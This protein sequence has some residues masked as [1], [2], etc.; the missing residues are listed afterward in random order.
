MGL[1]RRGTK[2]LRLGSGLRDCCCRPEKP[3]EC[4]CP[5]DLC[6][7]YWDWPGTS[8]SPPALFLKEGYVIPSGSGDFPQYG[9]RC[10]NAA[11]ALIKLETARNDLP[12]G[13]LLNG[14]GNAFIGYPRNDAVLDADNWF[15]LLGPYNLSFRYISVRG[16]ELTESFA[17]AAN[18]PYIAAGRNPL[19]YYVT[20]IIAKFLCGGPQWPPPPGAIIE[21]TLEVTF[22]QSVTLY[23]EFSWQDQP[24]EVFYNKRLVATAPLESQCVNEQN[25]WCPLSYL[26]TPTDFNQ[27]HLLG[28]VEIQVTQ[29]HLV[30]NSQNYEWQDTTVPIGTPGSEFF[31]A[32]DAS[33][34]QGWEVE[35][36]YPLQSL[37]FHLRALDTCQPGVCDCTASLS[38]RQVLFEGKT[39]NYGSLDN[40]YEPAPP[41]SSYSGTWWEEDPVGTFTRYDR[42]NCDPTLNQNIKKVEVDCINEGGVEKWVAYIDHTC[43]ERDDAVCPGPAD[44]QRV[45]QWTGFFLCDE[46]GSPTGSPTE[47]EVDYDVT[48]GTPAAECVDAL[49]PPS[50]EFL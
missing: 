6:R 32:V 25:Y 9:Y 7:Y 44:A 50:F 40:F 14:N 12:Y 2:L 27:L 38:G 19:G 31:N 11:P 46:N 48:S 36:D 4:W 15:F 43:N 22:S 45:K 28:D 29:E 3:E 35:P 49:Q 41:S 34:V 42:E 26:F 18:A 13:M 5:T 39:F 20:E 10:N 16:G 24:V 17:E 37:T 30:V 8:F 23:R 47:L 21:H 33:D 1:F